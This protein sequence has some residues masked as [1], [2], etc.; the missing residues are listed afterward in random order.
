V[1]ISILVVPFHFLLEVNFL[2]AYEAF[3]C[4]CKPAYFCD[5][6]DQEHLEHLRKSG[7][8]YVEVVKNQATLFFSS[9]E[10]K[11][12]F[13]SDMEGA[14]LY[15]SQYY[16]AVGVALGY[17]PIAAKFF[18]DYMKNKDLEKY[19]AVFEYA[20]RYF[21]GHINDT[22]QIA[23]WLWQ[24]VENFPPSPVQITYQGE[25]FSLHPDMC[26]TK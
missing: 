16:I 2:N 7:Y 26:Y 1:G 8:P 20:G 14:E 5:H 24:N 4:G 9:E 13:L 11:D 6:D 23:K 25:T 17:P 15:S 18:A 10:R 22:E 3:L 19:G 12:R 21:A